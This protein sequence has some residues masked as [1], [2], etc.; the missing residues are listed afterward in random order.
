MDIS[1][2]D[3]TGSTYWDEKRM[4]KA[5]SI[6]PSKVKEKITLPPC[7]DFS[8]NINLTSEI[9][10]EA[11]QNYVPTDPLDDAKSS[12]TNGTQNYNF[13]SCLYDFSI[14]TPP[15][16]SNTS[17]PTQQPFN[18]H[19]TP[20]QHLTQSNSLNIFYSPPTNNLN[21]KRKENP[22]TN[23]QFQPPTTIPKI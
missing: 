4:K 17:Q 16:H 5:Y 9:L 8:L 23:P 11:I 19:N 21:R 22:I 13:Q 3:R 18:F 15:Q 20:S 1:I 12:Q 6:D 14:T 7:F 2:F 10:A